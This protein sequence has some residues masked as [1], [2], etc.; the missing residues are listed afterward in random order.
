M[1]LLLLPDD[2]Q[3]RGLPLGRLLDTGE[4]TS[5]RYSDALQVSMGED[6]LAGGRPQDGVYFLTTRAEEPRSYD[7]HLQ[8]QQSTRK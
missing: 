4:L 3:L 5:H 2:R 1:L 6:A 8:W 7:S